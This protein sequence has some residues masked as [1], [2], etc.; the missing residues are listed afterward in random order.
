MYA[1]G[2][3]DPALIAYGKLY[4]ATFDGMV[5]CYDLKTGEHLW[6]YSTG[7]SGFETPYGTWPF[8]GGITIADGKIYAATS[9]HS[10]NVPLW[11]GERLHVVDA[12]TGKG[13]W[14]ILG[15]YNGP[16]LGA[17]II[18][19]P[20]VADGYLAAV[21]SADGQIYCFGKGKTAT[22]VS[23]GPKTIAN[24]SSVLI[25]G[26]ILDQS[27]GQPGTPCV[28]AKSQEQWMEYLHMQKPCPTNTTGVP[29]KLEAFGADGSYIDIGTVTSDAYGNFKSAWKPPKQILYTIMATFAGDD[30]YWMS[31]AATGLSVGPAPAAPEPV[32]IPA[33]PD[34]TPMF[35]VLIAAVVV[36]AILVVYDIFRKRK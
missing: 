26:T 4:A 14:S 21:N 29:V 3:G 33:Y 2:L 15:W 24:G 28:S 6:D 19:G 20:A 22:T 32:E 16:G 36:V 30:S 17:G 11:R 9:E 13:M 23:V 5:H 18:S 35:A 1:W 25:E 8:T 31:Y 10:P 7:S 27:P 12:E 34:Y